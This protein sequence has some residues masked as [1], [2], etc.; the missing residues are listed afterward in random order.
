MAF[1][2][3]M[4]QCTVFM[5]AKLDA[6]KDWKGSKDSFDLIKL[7]KAIEGFTYHFEKQNYHVMAL[8]QAKKSFFGLYQGRDT[9]DARYLDNFMTRVLV[10]DQYG[11]CIEKNDGAIRDE[12]SWPGVTIH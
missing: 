7:I 5:R 2:P 6:L 4:G 1:S 11:G 9:S 12:L 8:H 3:V 10:V